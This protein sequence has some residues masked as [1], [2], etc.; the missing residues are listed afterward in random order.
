MN[1]KSNDPYEANRKQLV[2]VIERLIG[3]NY[4]IE[5]DND[6]DIQNVIIKVPNI[7]LWD[8]GYDTGEGVNELGRDITGRIGSDFYLS[9]ATLDS[10]NFYYHFTTD[11]N[12]WG[13][14]ILH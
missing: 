1:A 14:G 6:G 2:R 9:H 8:N 7:A 11:P 13:R 5:Y 10:D 3:K 4:E 12:A